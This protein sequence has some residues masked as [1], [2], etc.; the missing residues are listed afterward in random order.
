MGKRDKRRVMGLHV[1][2]STSE[3]MKLRIL[4][5]NVRGANDLEKCKI[6]S[7]DIVC[8]QETKNTPYVTPISEES[9]GGQISRVGGGGSKGDN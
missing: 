5:W 6:Q 3:A 9:K 2:L 8:S 4:S 1:G 7:V